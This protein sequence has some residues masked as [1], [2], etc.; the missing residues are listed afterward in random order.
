[1]LEWAAVAAYFPISS[2][3]FHKN[4]IF[5]DCPGQK[6]PAATI[7]RWAEACRR[8][9]MDQNPSIDIVGDGAGD[10]PS[11]AGQRDR[12]LGLF[13]AHQNRIFRFIV[14]V[15][16]R[17]V[18]AEEVF[19]QTSL[20]L[21]QRWDEY[22]PQADFTAWACGIARNHLRN[23][24]RKKGNQQRLFSDDLLEQLSAL[25]VSKRSYLDELQSA[26]SRCLELL[27]ADRRRL[28]GLCYGE[29]RSIQDV[30]EREG[31]SPNSLYKLMRKVRETL[32][33]CI[34]T[35]VRSGATE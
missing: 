29:K 25:Q 15:V 8:G 30:A 13:L 20:T 19:Q 35:A 23:Y 10:Q 1:M 3:F 18:E 22:D 32:Y 21:W 2:R 14:A 9:N 27:P 26:L 31:R 11:A 6:P 34:M 24:L 17:G 7:R 5:F 16:P 28:V 4:R 12:F 33:D